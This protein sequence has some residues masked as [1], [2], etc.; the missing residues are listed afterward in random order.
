MRRAVTNIL[1]AFK[2]LLGAF[3]MYAGIVTMFVTPDS[4]LEPGFV[5]ESRF[6]LA[7]IGTAFFI[8]GLTLFVG[9]LTK[10]RR[11]TGHGLFMVYSCFLFATLLTLFTYGFMDAVPNL[12]GMLVSG[13]LYLRW[14]YHIYY[15]DPLDKANRK[16][17]SSTTA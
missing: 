17:Y 10:M 6:V 12:I 4:G 11:T 7:L 8:S 15:Y 13:G 1:S 3:M 16:R 14:K 2:Y 5:Y 9:K